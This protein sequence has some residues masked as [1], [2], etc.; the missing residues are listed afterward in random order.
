MNRTPGHLTSERSDVFRPLLAFMLLACV[1]VAGAGSFVAPAGAAGNSTVPALPRS[2]TAWSGDASVFLRW[3][4]PTGSVSAITR[5]LVTPI[6]DGRAM[7]LRSFMA[8][9]QVAT[10][11]G[12]ANGASV[13]LRIAAV[14]ASGTGPAAET[15]TVRVGSVPLDAARSWLDV[16]NYVRQ[17]SGVDPVVE[18]GEWAEGLHAH[19]RYLANTP[20]SQR[21]GAYAS[22]HAENPASRWFTKS[23]QSAAASADLMVGPVGTAQANIGVWLASP[24][25]A[26]GL[27]RPALRTTAYAAGER[28]AGIDVIRGLSESVVKPSGPVLLPGPGAITTARTYDSTERPNPLD[29]CSDFK[30]AGL[31]IVALLPS[32]PPRHVTASLRQ[33]DGTTLRGRDVC[34]ITAS[35][36]VSTDAVYG[37]AG[38]SVLEDSRAVIIIPRTPL[39]IGRQ[40]VSLYPA[41]S[42]PIIWSFTVS[43]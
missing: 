10:V 25:H 20:A 33:P 15:R 29:S 22:A 19:Y 8:P 39:Q 36:Y 17:T 21:V 34:L 24:F 3:S 26:I 35:N 11:T 40:T 28:A 32:T 1:T 42:T 4:P 23:G 7:P 2:V 5:Y 6:V 13:R 38:R 31:P 14:S 41:G 16:V 18:N 30:T 12:L 27:I 9:R 37:A 43:A